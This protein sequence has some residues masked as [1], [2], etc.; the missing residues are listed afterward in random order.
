MM[1]SL[2]E[3]KTQYLTGLLT[4]SLD[5]EPTFVEK[6]NKKYGEQKPNKIIVSTV[7][8]FQYVSFSHQLCY[9][10]SSILHITI[11]LHPIPVPA[12]H[13]SIPSSLAILR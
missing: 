11:F 2:D 6:L 8:R 1:G 4:F 10:Y 7:T 5:V 12:G 3:E 13:T 9:T